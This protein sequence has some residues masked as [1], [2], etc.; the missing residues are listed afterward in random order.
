MTAKS[1]IRALRPTHLVALRAFDS[2]ATVAELTAPAWPRVADGDGSL[3]L[4]S[5]LSHS[6]VHSTGLRRAWVHVAS[7]GLDG[8][9]I[10]RVRCGGLVWDVRHLWVDGAHD[11]VAQEL[12][13]RVCEEATARGARRVFLETGLETEER[14]IAARAGFEQYTEATLHVLPAGRRPS[15]PAWPGARPRRR[16][17]EFR[18]FQLYTVAVPAPVRAAEALTLAEWVA[19]HK[20][21]KRW[22]PGLLTNR[23]QQVWEHEDALVAWLEIAYGAKS[24]HA[25]WLVHPAHEAACDGLVAHAAQL[26]SPKQPL[27]A[28]TRIYQQPLASALDRAGFE[29]VARR[30]VFVRQ[31]AVRVPERAPERGLVAVRARPTLGG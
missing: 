25:E 12:L 26:V 5:L 22:A 30:A 23:Q 4:W 16:R 28:T 18:L 11:G 15:G 14:A 13:V 20:G 10:A 9:V 19:L 29:V 1:A 2:R 6:M 17:D 27:Y 8:L 24:Q 3:P 7:D 31:L 21:A